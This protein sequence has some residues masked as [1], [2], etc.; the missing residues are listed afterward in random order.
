MESPFVDVNWLAVVAS[1]VAGQIL[2]T[3]WFVVL[4][5]DAWAAEYGAADRAAHTK[6]I[7]G[8]T[9]AVQLACTV[10]MA[11]GLA[12]L[13]RWLSVDTAGE[14]VQLGLFVA[15]AFCV[16]TGLPG[17]AFLKR[18]RVAAISL[19]CQSTMLVVMSLILAVWR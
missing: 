18:W 13:Q 6:D 16:A 19:G 11:L 4:F 5:G 10:A 9:Y 14:G 12:A 2:S 15:I 3:V 1:I 17:Q 7:P 8:Y